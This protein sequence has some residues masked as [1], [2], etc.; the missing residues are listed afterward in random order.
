MHSSVAIEN[1][2]LIGVV[3]CPRLEPCLH[4]RRLS[5]EAGAWHDDGAAFPADNARVNEEV[6]RRALGNKGFGVCRQRARHIRQAAQC[7]YEIRSGVETVGRF[8]PGVGK[9][10]VLDRCRSL[11]LVVLNRAPTERQ[12]I[13][14]ESEEQR[15]AIDAESDPDAESNEVASEHLPSVPPPNISGRLRMRGSFFQLRII[16]KH[17]QPAVILEVSVHRILAVAVAAFKIQVRIVMLLAF[18]ASAAHAQEVTPPATPIV[19]PNAEHPAA[20]TMQ[21]PGMTMS[22]GWQL[23]QDGVVTGLFNHQ[24]GPRGDDEFVVPNWWMGMFTREKGRYQFGVNTMFSL[25]PATVGKSGYA[26]IFQVGEALDGKPV[27]DRQHPHDLFM[28]L[29]ASWRIS[30]GEHTSL[31]LAGGPAGEPD[32]GAGAFMHRPSAAGLGSRAARSPHVRLDPHQLRRRDR[33]PRT[34]PMGI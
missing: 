21:M 29:A 18:T 19:A 16:R 7:R 27:I 33:V 15:L 28:Q 9:K 12:V 30:F 13:L 20:R 1:S 26:E 34:G 31:M 3:R 23:M 5:G 6:P 4:Q 25:D 2:K 22:S 24:G 14:F 11:R 10:I 32:A 17:S 8:T